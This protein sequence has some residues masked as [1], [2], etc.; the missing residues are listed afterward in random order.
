MGC[1]YCHG[2]EAKGNGVSGLGA[3]DIRGKT[4]AQ[5]RA[6]LAGGVPLMSFIKLTDEEIAAVFAY[7]QY[8]NEQS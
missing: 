2:P 7:L 6:A 4:E 5:V 3:P 8:L 1:A